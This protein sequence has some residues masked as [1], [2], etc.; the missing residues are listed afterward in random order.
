MQ[1]SITGEVVSSLSKHS[2][3]YFFY[4]RVIY[5]ILL[6]NYLKQVF[7]FIKETSIKASCPEEEDVH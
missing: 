5:L 7:S 4:I 2:Y 3:L 6:F 1:I